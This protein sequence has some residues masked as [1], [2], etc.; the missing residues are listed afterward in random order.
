[1]IRKIA[2]VTL[3]YKVI[4]VADARLEG[5]RWDDKD[6]D[7]AE[8]NIGH[9]PNVGQ[10]QNMLPTALQPLVVS[11]SSQPSTSNYTELMQKSEKLRA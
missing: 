6:R 1:M 7:E 4:R 10:L 3:F 5:D 9:P 8:R 11:S 2:N